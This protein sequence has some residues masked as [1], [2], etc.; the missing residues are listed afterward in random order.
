MSAEILEHVLVA[1]ER[2]LLR[3]VRP[4]DALPGFPLIHRVDEVLEWLVWPGPADEAE[5]RD[6]YS[7]WCA[8][9]AAG[10]N[11]Q[12]AIVERATE[13]FTGTIS[14]RFAGHPSVADLGYWIGAEFHGR[15]IGTDAVLLATRLAVGP[16]AARVVTAEVFI[17]NEASARV[18][19]KVGFVEEEPLAMRPLDAEPGRADRPR[20]PFSLSA[21]RWADPGPPSAIWE[22]RPAGSRGNGD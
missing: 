20:R 1:G 14:I 15:G 11:Y 22:V 19:A 12:L 13:R 10:T 18:L 16:L 6:R 21:G 17:G 4:A 5:L 7:T 8:P 9:S 3:P 2:A